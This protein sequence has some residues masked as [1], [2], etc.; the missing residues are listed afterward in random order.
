M[1]GRTA[2]IAEDLARSAWLHPRPRLRDPRRLRGT[3][4][5]TLG[6][7]VDGPEGTRVPPARCP[8]YVGAAP[9]RRA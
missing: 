8:G 4:A 1:A 7:R 9:T 3:A 5:G 2:A 6:R